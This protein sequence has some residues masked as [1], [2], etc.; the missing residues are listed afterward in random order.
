MAW[1]W[2][3]EM[4]V[5]FVCGSY[6]RLDAAL[7]CDILSALLV[8]SFLWLLGELVAPSYTH[9][10]SSIRSPCSL[11]ELCVTCIPANMHR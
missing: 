3:N 1:D 8:F 2:T 5:P 4:L 9:P 10:I 11:L 6:R 7:D